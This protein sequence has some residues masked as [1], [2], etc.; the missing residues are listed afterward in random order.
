MQ[1]THRRYYTIYTRE[2]NPNN[3]ILIVITIFNLIHCFDKLTFSWPSLLMYWPRSRYFND[4][5]EANNNSV[6]E[7]LN[8]G[9]LWAILTRNETNTRFCLDQLTVHFGA[10]VLLK[11]AEV[12]HFGFNLDQNQQNLISL[13][14]INPCYLCVRW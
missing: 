4:S 3:M 7:L 6:S 10:L 1:L 12:F 14:F 8:M 2:K 5:D 11:K 13:P 9:P